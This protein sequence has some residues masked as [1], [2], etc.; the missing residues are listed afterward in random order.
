MSRKPDPITRLVQQCNP[1]EAFE[2]TDSRFVDFTAARG[3]D[4]LR[5]IERKLPQGG[6]P[7]RN[8]DAAPWVEMPSRDTSPLQATL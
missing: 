4:T 7:R 5:R 3:I 2:P 6:T 8:R 1:N